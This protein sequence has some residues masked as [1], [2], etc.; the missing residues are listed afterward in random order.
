MLEKIEELL[1]EVNSFQTQSKD[2][3]EQFRIKFSGKKGILNDFFEKFKE[4]PNEQK[5][6]F[7]QKINTLKQAVNNKLEQLKEATSSQIIIEKE[8]LTKP[9]FPLELGSRHPINLVKNRNVI[10]ALIAD[11]I[12]IFLKESAIR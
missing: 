2:E 5:K 9:A 3:I 12:F 4:V 1:V 10:L 6:D 7:G 8:D 11:E